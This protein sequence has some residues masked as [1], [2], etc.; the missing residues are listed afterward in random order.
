MMPRGGGFSLTG[1]QRKVDIPMIYTDLSATIIVPKDVIDPA[2]HVV[3]T[4][5]VT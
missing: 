2:C 3:P 5:G 4:R 1:R